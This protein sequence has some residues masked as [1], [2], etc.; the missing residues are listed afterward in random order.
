MRPRSVVARSPSRWIIPT[1]VALLGSVLLG[2]PVPVAAVDGVADHPAAFSA[3]MGPATDPAGFRDMKG[4]FAEAAADCLAYYGITKGTSVGI[5]SPNDVVPRW[6]MALFLVRAAGPAG[7]VVPRASDQGFTDLEQLGP[8]TKE[9]I[10]QLAALRIMQG[11]SATTFAP[12]ADVTRQQMALLLSRFL[13]AAPTGPGGSDIGSIRPDDDVF[14]D[15]RPVAVTTYRAIRALY[16]LGVTSGTSA[17]TFSPD[18]AVSR[19]QMAV[20][21]ARMLAHANARPTGLT[22]Q[23]ADTEVFKNS[24]IRLAI[25]LRDSNQRPFPD[26]HVDIFVATD[27]SKAF[28]QNGNCTE[29][30]SPA[31]TGDSCTID[32][33]DTTTDDLGNLLVDV[34]VGNVKSLRIWAWTDGRGK[35]FDEDSAEPAVLDIVARSGASALEVADDLPPTAKKV[36][37]GD[38]VTFA[39][40]MIDDDGDPV[41]RSGVSFTVQVQE[42]RD[43]GRSFERTTITK[44][45][46][47]D[48]GTQLTFRF[49]DPSSDPGDIA[50]LDLDI[51]NSGGF[52]VKD[53]T[54]IGMV[55]DDRNSD[56]PF[57]DWADERAKPTTLRLTLTKEYRIA[58]SDGAG[59]AATVRADLTDQYGGPV[60]RENIVFTS[61]DRDGVPS[62]VRRLTNR[63]GVASLNYLRDSSGRGIETITARF[64]RLSTTARQYWIAPFSGSA[65][66][67]GSIRIL[68]T[69]D[70]TIVVASGNDA[71]LIEYD[72]NDQYTVDTD[73]VRLAVFEENLTVGDTLEYDIVDP[74]EET[75][76]SFTLTNH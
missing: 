3:C 57:L 13:K 52:K 26:R 75:V 37:M 1:L 33:S 23:I 41:A 32:T 17:T 10:N 69:D 62:G 43:N 38:S 39:F 5:F 60:A 9:A 47:P 65:N 19:A 28:D 24:D 4:S 31:V 29:H 49:T 30:V 20:F 44:E 51:R 76:N 56:D 50:K 54:T 45:T 66:G 61:N 48:G 67:S 18:S 7:I 64:D 46:G 21:I 55:G 71:F 73:P 59:A 68:D 40:R 35:L 25:S 12:L 16:E 34:E 36:Q 11:T 6:Q 53:E 63:Q 70:N 2:P 8:H 72:D 14:R 74:D 27:P 15:L 22:V 42:S 58:S